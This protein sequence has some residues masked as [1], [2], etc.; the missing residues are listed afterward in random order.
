MILHTSAAERGQIF[1]P[2][3]NALLC[4]AVIGLVLGFRSSAGLAAAFG[5]AVTSTM[6]LTTL[7]MG[8]V[9]FRIWRLRM[10][11]AGP[12]YVGC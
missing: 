5:F 8:F 12:L 7:I 1:A 6:V 9:M 3:V 4:V 2:A 11:W 10:I